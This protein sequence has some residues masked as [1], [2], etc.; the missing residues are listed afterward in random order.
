MPPGSRRS[1]ILGGGSGARSAW[2]AVVST[3]VFF[4]VAATLILNS[5]GWPEIKTTFFNG[6]VLRE[7]FPEIVRQFGTNVFIFIVAEVLVL[8]VALGLAVMR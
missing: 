3:V 8:I 6:R 4:G 1:R 5:P 7:S 2:I